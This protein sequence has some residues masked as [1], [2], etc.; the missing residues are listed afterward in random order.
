MVFG[1]KKR[2]REEEGATHV[3]ETL[4]AEDATEAAPTGGDGE[5]R[6]PEPVVEASPAPA[7]AVPEDLEAYVGQEGPHLVIRQHHF[8][9]EMKRDAEDRLATSGAGYEEGRWIPHHR[10]PLADVEKAVD[11]LHYERRYQ[12]VAAGWLKLHERQR[13]RA[14]EGLEKVPANILAKRIVYETEGGFVVEVTYRERGEVWKKYFTV[15]RGGGRAKALRALQSGHY[16]KATI[17]TPTQIEA[18]PSVRKPRVSIPPGKVLTWPVRN[19]TDVLDVEGIGKVYARRLHQLGISTTDQLR[20]MSAEVLAGHL[21]TSA[22]VVERWQRMAELLVVPGIGKQY[23]ELLVDSGITSIDQL[24]QTTPKALA[25]VINAYL[26]TRE[27]TRTRVRTARTQSWTRAARRLK[28]APQ[29][30]PRSADAS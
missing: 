1:R 28:K 16:A 4:V 13:Q 12:S 23:A 19:D 30:F 29:P 21:G 24:R 20:L 26:E 25:G 22:R 9:R 7:V 3:D 14:L 10:L 27:S 8:T 11:K 15:P 6:L 2:A 5:S 18:L 17:V